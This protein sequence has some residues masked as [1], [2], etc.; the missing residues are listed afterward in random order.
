MS[1]VAGKL[2]VP[3]VSDSPLHRGEMGPSEEKNDPVWIVSHAGFTVFVRDHNLL[4]YALQEA[5]RQTAVP[6]VWIVLRGQDPD[7]GRRS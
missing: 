7:S 3:L 6:D 1:S 2:S 5:Q 4:L